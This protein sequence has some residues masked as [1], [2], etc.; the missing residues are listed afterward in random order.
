MFLPLY[1]SVCA[2][3]FGQS[4]ADSPV[5]CRPFYRL[6]RERASAQAD[7]EVLAVPPEGTRPIDTMISCMFLEVAIA[8][9]NCDSEYF[10]GFI[11][12]HASA[13]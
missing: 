10:R 3:Q 13:W 1:V 11:R 4:K 5:D 7:A 2:W 9:A 8:H 6:A 12:R